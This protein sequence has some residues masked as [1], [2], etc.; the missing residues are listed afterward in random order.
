M[1]DQTLDVVLTVSAV[2]VWRRLWNGQRQNWT[3]WAACQVNERLN[4]GQEDVCKDF[5]RNREQSNGAV[6]AAVH[7]W[8]FSFVQCYQ[9][10]VFPVRGYVS[11]SPDLDEDFVQS[12]RDRINCTFE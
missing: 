6:A 11:C 7:F 3:V 10:A 1:G 4:T 8:S 9:D 12:L 5:A 2:P